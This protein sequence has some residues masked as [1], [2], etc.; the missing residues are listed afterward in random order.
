MLSLLQAFWARAA[1]RKT[2]RARA[3][4]IRVAMAARVNWMDHSVNTRVTVIMDIPVSGCS[5]SNGILRVFSYIKDFGKAK[6][7]SIIP[8]S[9][10][11]RT[12][13]LVTRQLAT[14]DINSLHINPYPQKYIDY[15][16]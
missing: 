8:H 10:S 6:I 13:S 12:E 7:W 4:R 11:P 14:Y 2:P 16:K 15:S 1:K 3:S 5:K 9:R